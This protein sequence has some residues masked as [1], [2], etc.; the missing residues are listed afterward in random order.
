MVFSERGLRP[1]IPNLLQKNLTFGNY[2]QWTYLYGLHFDHFDRIG[3]KIGFLESVLKYINNEV[4]NCLD[5]KLSKIIKKFFS[6]LFK[7]FLYF[8]DLK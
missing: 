3:F 6:K 1:R 8:L 2:E 4:L 5:I 7:N